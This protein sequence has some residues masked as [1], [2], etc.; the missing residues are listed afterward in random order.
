M[1]DS[2]CTYDLGLELSAL[3]GHR[4]DTFDADRHATRMAWALV[5]AT[6]LVAEATVRSVVPTGEARRGAEPQV[7]TLSSEDLERLSELAHGSLHLDE[8]AGD[9]L[10]AM[11][12]GAPSPGVLSR[13]RPS[14]LVRRC[15][16]DVRQDA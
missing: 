3:I 9:A 14:D 13:L 15:P 2:L 11:E 5:L 1:T 16:S 10:A 6:E 4:W 7:V 8:D 12:R